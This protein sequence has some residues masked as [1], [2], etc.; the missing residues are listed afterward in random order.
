MN[1]EVSAGGVVVKKINGF[2]HVLLIKDRHGDWMLPKGHIEK[3]ETSQEAAKREIA[4]ETCQTH[5]KLMT[6]LHS[7]NYSFIRGDVLIDKT[8]HFFLFEEKG[9]EPLIP[10]LSEGITQAGWFPS[11][12]AKAMIAFKESYQPVLDEAMQ[13]IQD[14][15]L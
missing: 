1:T 8:I 5:L 6:A 12:E 10:Q 3:G 2:V 11:E 7:M 4:E 9:D 13:F 14:H 15:P